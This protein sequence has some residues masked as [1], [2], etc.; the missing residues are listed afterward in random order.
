VVFWPDGYAI[1]HDVSRIAPALVVAGALLLAGCGADPV[2]EDSADVVFVPCS[3]AE[4]S[5]RLP[6]GADFEILMP[7][8]WNGS[9]ALY[10]HGVR[11][12]EGTARKGAAQQAGADRNGSAT[13]VATEGPQP[14]AGWGA[15]ERNVADVL[16][17][18]GYA[19][20]GA[21]TGRLGW[22]V[23]SQIE[24][25]EEL[26]DYF[27]EN[28]AD[29]TRVYVWG[30]STGGLASARLA[31]LHPE[32]VAGAAAL[33]AP[34]SGPLPSFELA[35]DAGYAVRQLLD[36]DSQLV[37][38]DSYDEALAVR[39]A[40]IA[41]VRRAAAE[42]DD[43]RAKVL[44]IASV[45]DLPLKTAAESGANQSSQV[46]AA[47]TGI[48]NLLEQN[49]AQR[50][51]LEQLVG[52]NPS[53]NENTD[54]AARIDEDRREQLNILAPGS[55]EKNLELLNESRVAAD[56]DAQSAAAVQGELV[57]DL[58]VPVLTLHNIFDPVYIVQ[59]ES[60]YRDRVGTFS[61]EIRANL[62]GAYAVPPESYS[63]AEPAREGA[64]NCNFEP[65][66]LA[67]ALVQ[68]DLW[69]RKGQYPGRD[70]LAKTFD[71]QQV[72]LEYTPEPWPQMDLS[73][74]ENPLE[75]D[76]A[77]VYPAPPVDDLGGPSPTNDRRSESPSAS[78]SPKSQ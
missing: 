48:S 32:W 11:M 38:F 24:A 22:S 54:Y 43:G 76:P 78:T 61:T 56:P 13:S 67:A 1:L 42:D 69:V 77:D 72:T 47:V 53:G 14:A 15:T 29:P 9:L 8:T 30:E 2:A 39:N 25:A 46:T 55:V 3:E 73:P 31:E 5:G 50:Y 63:A 37:D 26:H 40:A 62:V 65:R 44:F 57:G 51:L 6:S 59:N 21:S 49:T 74:T 18:A 41:A 35:L 71:G 4:C 12:P 23:R 33:C 28:V 68:L 52:G 10:S 58:K 20:A 64:G 36:E 75:P 60:W 19:L 66:T 27:V 17:Q 70:S 16:L 34:M 7:E 45:L